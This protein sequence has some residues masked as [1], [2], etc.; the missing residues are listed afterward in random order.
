MKE[1]LKALLAPKSSV[2]ELG[3]GVSVQIR[4]LSLR[5]RIA[6]RSESIG[7]D[8]KLGDDWVQNLLFRAVRDDDG[9]PVWERPEDVDGSES[10]LGKLLEAVQGVNGLGADKAQEGN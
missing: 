4:E 8:G 1:S 2:F 9:N 3:Q 6:W 7:P 5:E 10:V